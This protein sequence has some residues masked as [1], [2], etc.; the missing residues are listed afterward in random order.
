MMNRREF[1]KDS[2]LSSLTGLAGGDLLLNR[3][4]AEAMNVKP[5][6]SGTRHRVYS[7]L[8][9]PREHPDYSRHHVQ[10]PDWETFGGHTQFAALRT[11]KIEDKRIVHYAEEI[12]KY[13]RE[14]ELGNVL[15]PMY[16]ILYAENLDDLADEIKRRKLFLFDVWAY[17]P[18]SGPGGVWQQFRPPAGVFE[19]LEAKL[20]DHWLGMDNGEQDGR[21]VGGYAEEMY[22]SSASK[23]QQYL[24]FQRHFERLTN[25]L[26]NKMSTLVSLNFGHYFLKEGVY[27]LIGAETGEALPNGQIYYSFIRGAGKQYGVPWFGNA[28]GWNRWGWKVYSPEERM[29]QATGGP[30]KGTSLSLLKRL[31]Y[32]HILYNSVLVGFDQ[33]WFYG[34]KE[35]STN[36]TSQ[37]HTESERLSPIGDVQRGAGRWVREVGQPGAMVTPIALIVDFFA[38]WTFPRHLYTS[39]VYRVWGNLPYEAG[40][41]L[42]DG[43]LDMLY[44]GYQDSSYFHNESGFLTPTPYGDAAD[45]LLSDAPGW[46]LARYPLL[47]VAGGLEGGAEIRDKFE[48]YAKGGG[49]L[50]MTAGSLAKLPGGLAGIEVERRLKH[51]KAGTRVE[52]DKTTLE[53]ES[54][55]DMY[56]L[57]VPKAAQMRAKVS[58][59]PA[60]VEMAYGE[61]RITVFAS[62][63]GVGAKEAAGVEAA[64]AEE[65]KNEVDKP[66]AKPFPLLQHVRHLLDEAFRST[67]LFEVGE[68]LSLITC[69]KGAGEYTLGVSNNTWRQQPLEIVSHCGQIESLR[70]LPLDQSEKGAVGYLPEGFEKLELGL[71][72]K[73]TMAGGDIRIFAVRVQEEKVEEIAHVAPPARPQGRALVLREARSIKEEVLARPSFF[74]HFDSVVVDWRYLRERTKEDLEREAGWIGLQKLKFYIDLTSGINFY[75]DLRLLDNLKADYLASLAAIEDVMGKM[76][77]LQAHDLILS[78]HRYPENNFTRAQS[79]QSFEATLRQ[80]CEGAR[81]QEGRVYLRLSLN[82]PPEDLNKAVEFVGRVGALN[83]RLAPSTAFLL[84]K[85]TGLS[86][87]RKLLEGKVGLWLLDTPQTD[88]VGRTWNGHAPIRGY[89]DRQGLA[90]ILAIAPQA[91]LVFNGVYKNHDEEYLDAKTLRQILT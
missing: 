3:R 65:V 31:M 39:N 37:A 90:N 89:R 11:F 76:E 45:C 57:T 68:G 79:W 41:Y 80:I 63:F 43:V 1:V 19:M 13:T 34:Q 62:P 21:Y 20:G 87:A 77:I 83:L 49:H 71:S 42:T 16:P 58:G 12:E 59:I 29:G 23:R 10:P 35:A 28:S 2:L 84:A 27:T 26:G 51:F 60:A 73:N 53:E 88:I 70:E 55:F 38:G 66:L 54:P 14:Y 9:D 86:E 75:P 7:H 5:P 30:T 17:V 47:V 69:R 25:E 85:K 50:L 40:D 44:P 91:P 72:S 52:L 61:G 8:L 56:L 82:K 6:A 64:L 24:N 36:S 74:E 33:G 4:P 48:A 46:L 15:W 78:L 67:M 22:P 81:R 18:G 32:N